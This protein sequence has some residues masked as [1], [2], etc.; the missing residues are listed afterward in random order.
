M[1]RYWFSNKEVEYI[2]FQSVP[3]KFESPSRQKLQV[4]PEGINDDDN[5][6]ACSQKCLILAERRRNN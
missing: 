1:S 4:K 2:V 5:C 6:L 3:G